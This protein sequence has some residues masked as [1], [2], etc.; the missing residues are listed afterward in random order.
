MRIRQLAPPIF[1]NFI[2]EIYRLRRANCRTR[3][4]NASR[5]DRA[6]RARIDAN[7][8]GPQQRS[9]QN[10][11]KPRRPPSHTK[12]IR[13]SNNN[14]HQQQ[15]AS[16][17]QQRVTMPAK[18]V[19]TPPRRRRAR[20]T[21]NRCGPVLRKIN[22]HR[23][24]RRLPTSPRE[25][26]RQRLP[27]RQPIST[28]PQLTSTRHT[29]IHTRR[30]NPRPRSQRTC[31]L[32]LRSS[33]RS[34]RRPIKPKLVLGD[35]LATLNLNTSDHH[36]TRC[37]QIRQKVAG[38]RKLVG[39]RRRL[40]PLP[41][42][43]TAIRHPINNTHPQRPATNALRRR[44]QQELRRPSINIGITLE[45]QRLRRTRTTRV[46]HGCSR[47]RRLHNITTE[48]VRTRVLHPIP[49]SRQRIRR[50]NL[51]RP[52]NP[53]RRDKPNHQQHNHGS[54]R[55]RPAQ[56]NTTRPPRTEPR[57]S[58]RLRAILR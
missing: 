58:R 9:S 12:A 39:C 5:P 3:R 52:R 40:Q 34:K 31:L 23:R 18:Q 10:H 28:N 29:L 4:A 57:Q 17:Q 50:R 32:H 2:H 20:H 35:Q 55:H 1:A 30:N 48:M 7:H 26:Q 25:L 33:H 15:R 16:Q 27:H 46:D 8:L 43:L 11:S 47:R 49:R 37:T 21:R 54:T 24:R 51:T 45:I 6:A 41:V 19:S 13:T 38:R 56:S 44:R 22:R 14:Q 53:I 36:I 42:T